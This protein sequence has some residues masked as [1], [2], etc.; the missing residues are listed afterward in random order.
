MIDVVENTQN[1]GETEDIKNRFPGLQFALDEIRFRYKSE[2]DRRQNMEI[3]SKMMLVF[4]GVIIPITS[5]NL[6]KNDWWVLSSL[7]FP[8]Y[9]L[10]ILAMRHA[11]ETTKVRSYKIPLKKTGDFYQYAKMKKDELQDLFLTSY[12]KATED[13]ENINS[14]KLDELKKTIKYTKYSIVYLVVYVIVNSLI[15][16]FLL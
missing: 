4:L 7:I 2:D 3:K 10:V 8:F 5:L 14:I 15:T 13:L 11:F 6:V 9:V 16:F 12:I 1:E